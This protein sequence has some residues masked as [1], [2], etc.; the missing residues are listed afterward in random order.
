MRLYGTVLSVSAV[1]IA[2][3]FFHFCGREL[4]YDIF[5]YGT[6]THSED[7]SQSFRIAI[8]GLVAFAAAASLTWLVYAFRHDYRHRRKPKGVY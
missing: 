3:V 7:I 4:R 5:V 6:Y 8:T 1:L 2:A